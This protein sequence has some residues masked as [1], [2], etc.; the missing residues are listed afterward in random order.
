MLLKDSGFT[1][2]TFM[3]ICV[4]TLDFPTILDGKFTSSLHKSY[5]FEF[6]IPCS[7]IVLFGNKMFQQEFVNAWCKFIL[8]KVS[9]NDKIIFT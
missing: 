4:S 5:C 3:T 7:D 6:M 1:G 9:E 8:V 2:I